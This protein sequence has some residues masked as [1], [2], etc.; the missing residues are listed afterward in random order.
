MSSA[1]FLVVNSLLL[2]GLVYVPNIMASVHRVESSL[3]GHLLVTLASRHFMVSEIL[4]SRCWSYKAMACS[5]RGE[6]DDH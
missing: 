5:E 1:L 4:L 3:S 6:D 2:A